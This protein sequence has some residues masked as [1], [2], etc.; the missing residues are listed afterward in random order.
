MWGR[1]ALDM[2]VLLTMLLSVACTSGEDYIFV[3]MIWN[4]R[5]RPTGI[6]WGDLIQKK[7]VW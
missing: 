2:C 4:R 5:L 3:Y 7:A 6:P 1:Q